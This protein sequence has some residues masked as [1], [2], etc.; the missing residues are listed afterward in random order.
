MDMAGVSNVYNFQAELPFSA[1]GMFTIRRGPIKSQ[2]FCAIMGQRWMNFD[3]VWLVLAHLSNRAG[4]EAHIIMHFCVYCDKQQRLSTPE[5][6]PRS[7]DQRQL[8]FTIVLPRWPWTP[9]SQKPRGFPATSSAFT[10]P[11]HFHIKPLHPPLLVIFHSAIVELMR[12]CKDYQFPFYRSD[13][14][15]K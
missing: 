14:N 10:N 13:N 9:S 8:W 6:I 12:I 1:P 5:K 15:N 7:H 2:Q 11:L 3:S 4:Y